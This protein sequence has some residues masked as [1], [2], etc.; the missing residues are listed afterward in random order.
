MCVLVTQSC[1]TLCDP[2]D[3]SPPDSPVH[4]ILQARILEWVV[5]SFSRGSSQPRDWTWDYCI[6]D[7]LPTESQGRPCLLWIYHIW[8][9]LCWGIF[10]LCLLLESFY[11]PTL[12]FNFCKRL[13]LHLLRWSYFF[14][15]FQF[16]NMLNHI[17]GFAYTNESL[18]PW[19][20]YHL[21]MMCD[22][23]SILLDSA[24]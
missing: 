13:S 16:V 6:A 7:T 17:D 18:H 22:H 19:D 23:F 9:Y 10:L 8:P 4:G 5:I 12:V 2:T 11:P 3:S 24:C 15:I 20:K 1:P 21:I 14:F